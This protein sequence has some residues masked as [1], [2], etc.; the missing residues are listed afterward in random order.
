MTFSLTSCLI[1]VNDGT[2]G[3]RTAPAFVG[4]ESTPMVTFQPVSTHGWFG[5]LV[6]KP[7]AMSSRACHWCPCGGKAHVCYFLL[8]R[9]RR[10]KAR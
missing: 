9:V 2:F 5:L 4:M 1:G 7:F 10:D 8:H 6:W 3:D